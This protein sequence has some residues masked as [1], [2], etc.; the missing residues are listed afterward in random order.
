M[1]RAAHLLKHTNQ[2]VHEITWQ[3]GFEN[4]SAFCRAFKSHY[5]VQPIAFRKSSAS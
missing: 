5:G 2:P 4:V 3:C 1:Q